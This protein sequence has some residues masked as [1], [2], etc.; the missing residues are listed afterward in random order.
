M[1]KTSR[2]ATIIDASPEDVFSVLVDPLAYPKWVLGAK[3][4]RHVDGVWPEPGSHFGHEV[5]AGPA[6]VKDDTEALKVEWPRRLELDV[7][8][9]P[10]GTARVEIETTPHA[11]ASTLVTL[12]ETPTGGRV[13][14]AEGLPIAPMLVRVLLDLRNNWSLVRLRRIVEGRTAARPPEDGVTVF[15]AP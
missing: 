8:F 14:C 6:A 1:K 11:D 9:R 12:Q 4:I 13:K 5:G 10:I 7:R 3:R 2:T 15:V